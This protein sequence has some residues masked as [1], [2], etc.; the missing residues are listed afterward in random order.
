MREYRMDPADMR[1]LTFGVKGL[2]HLFNVSTLTVYRMV[3]AGTFPMPIMINRSLRWPR[4]IVQRWLIEHNQ[5]IKELNE[6]ED[7]FK[8]PHWPCFEDAPPPDPPL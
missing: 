1:R 4:A 7:N 6:A 3:A 2:A 5:G 8:T